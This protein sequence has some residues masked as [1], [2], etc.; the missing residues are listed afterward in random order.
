MLCMRFIPF[1]PR[2]DDIVY[3]CENYQ[4]EWMV[5][6]CAVLV[7]IVALYLYRKVASNEHTTY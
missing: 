3:T 5:V 6:A 7:I 2:F 1:F 4:W